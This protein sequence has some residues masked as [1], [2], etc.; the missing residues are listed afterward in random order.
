[1]PDPRHCARCGAS[2]VRPADPG[3]KPECPECGWFRPTNAL[4]VVLV[5]AGTADGK[6][7]YTRK[8]GWPLGA[9]GLVAGYVEEGETAELAAVREVGEESSLIATRPRLLW[10]MHRDELL[11]PPDLALTPADWPARTLIESQL[12]S[13]SSV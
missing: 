2:L 12:A 4:P 10:T 5:L 8:A 6:I 9:W 1:M 7:L 13:R 3:H 11:V